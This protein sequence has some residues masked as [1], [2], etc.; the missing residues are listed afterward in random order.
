MIIEVE[1]ASRIH[2]YQGQ[3]RIGSLVDGALDMADFSNLVIAL[4]TPVH[5][6]LEAIAS[7]ITRPKLEYPGNFLNFEF[8]AMW[9]V[10][11][12]LANAISQEGHGGAL[13]MLP[14]DMVLGNDL[15]LKYALESERLGDGLVKFLNAR[16][17]MADACEEIEEGAPGPPGPA[18]EQ[19]WTH[20]EHVENVR[21]VAR[22]AQC[23]GAIVLTQSLK[24][25]GFGAEIRS[26]MRENSEVYEVLQ[27][28]PS[29]KRRLDVEQFGMR[30]RSA[31]KFVSQHEG[32]VAIIVSQD[33]PVSIVWSESGNVFVRHGVRIVN[34]N[35][36]WG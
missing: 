9:N 2:V 18:Q 27:E 3:Y 6:G 7:K 22:L 31:V 8:L 23:D 21:F 16:H 26:T 5:R 33:G 10:Y 12:S 24:V 17:A 34:S 19:Y 13:L 15:R 11:A 28:I 1:R 30:H 20:E 36:P 14:D 35:I 32:A 29:R 25:L 4:D